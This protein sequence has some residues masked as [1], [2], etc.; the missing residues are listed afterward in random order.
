M[1]RLLVT[2]DGPNRAILLDEH[3]AP[4]R[5]REGHEAEELIERLAWSIE[6]AACAETAFRIRD[7]GERLQH[8]LLS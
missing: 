3:V 8:A 7:A 1:P 4:D 6:D 5:L 2:T